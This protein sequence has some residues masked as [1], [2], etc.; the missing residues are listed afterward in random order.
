MQQ[1]NNN[2]SAAT[3]DRST[4]NS[5]LMPNIMS[6]N[7][8]ETD[9]KCSSI[10]SQHASE[11]HHRQSVPDLHDSANGAMVYPVMMGPGG[12]YQPWH[13][14]WT[15]PSVQTHPSLPAHWAPQHHTVQAPPQGVQRQVIIMPQQQNTG[16]AGQPSYHLANTQSALSL[17]QGYKVMQ[18]GDFPN[19]HN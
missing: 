9:G 1:H 2:L 15:H 16:L 18:P 12:G 13:H 17:G 10:E 6:N 11:L 5:D 14:T 8:I 19:M 4:S 7:S 3:R